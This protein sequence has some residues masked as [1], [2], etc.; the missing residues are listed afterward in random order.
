[1]LRSIAYVAIVLVACS[2]D[3]VDGACCDDHDP[4]T[5]DFCQDDTCV[6]VPRNASIACQA[7]SHC[8]D[9]NPCT[10]DR[11]LVDE[12]SLQ[13]CANEPDLTCST[14]E[15]STDCNDGNPCTT[16]TC[17]DDKLCNFDVEVEGCEPKCSLGRAISPSDTWQIF[18]GSFVGTAQPR[19]FCPG[20]GCS[21]DSRMVLGDDFGLVELDSADPENAFVCAVDACEETPVVCGPLMREVAYI[22]WGTPRSE[23]DPMPDG[24]AA[25]DPEPSLVDT[26]VVEGFCLS[27]R[28]DH[29]VG[30]Y[31]VRFESE[32]GSSSLSA[33]AWWN[34]PMQRYELALTDCLDCAATGFAAPANAP[35]G[36]LSDIVSFPVMVGA[37]QG[38]A[39]LFGQPSAFVGSVTTEAGKFLGRLTL[40]R[41]PPE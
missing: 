8:D 5:D 9:G 3:T 7:D 33:I 14:C 15:L 26:L 16:D 19:V 10:V 29:L 24:D 1:M 20:E 35:L 27:P 41:L 18:S 2:D 25:V 38:T 23:G 39:V 40:E 37:E 30:R 34:T 31:K 6:H 36:D 4:C 13:R 32:R 21:C 11:C 17:G 22:V 28:Q 12:C